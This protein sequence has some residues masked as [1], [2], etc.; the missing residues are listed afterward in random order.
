MNVLIYHEEK[1]EAQRGMQTPI[2]QDNALSEAKRSPATGRSG[3]QLQEHHRPLEP[4][5]RMHV[6]WVITRHDQIL[7]PKKNTILAEDEYQ[8]KNI[9]LPK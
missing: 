6:G 4:R 1:T 8:D 2:E 3:A 7:K 9:C 5:L